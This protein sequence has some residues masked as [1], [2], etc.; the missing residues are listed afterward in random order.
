MER[1]DLIG[2][3]APLCMADGPI[4]SRLARAEELMLG[5]ALADECSVYLWD[6][7]SASFVLGSVVE[8]GKGRV[9]S[10][11]PGEG[12]PGLLGSSAAEVHTEVSGQ[13]RFEGREDR[14]L[15]GFASASVFA[16][17]EPKTL[18]G[19]LYLKFRARASLRAPDRELIAAAVSELALLLGFEELS[20]RNAG[21]GV[22]LD[23]CRGRLKSAEKLAGLA[24]M[25]ATLAH[26]IKSP[27]VSIGGFASRLARKLG[28][29]SEHAGC[30]EQMLTEIRRLEK[31]LNG[32]TSFLM[33]VPLDLRAEDLNAILT[34]AL[35]LFDEEFA[36]HG[37]EVVKGF[38]PGSLSVSA[39]R[40]ELKIAF[41]N[42][43]ANAIQSMDAG[44]VLTL[45][46]EVEEG[47]VVAAFSDTGGGI[48]QANMR[49]IFTPFFTTKEHGTGLG[50]S[51]THSIIAR[52]KGSI[53]VVAKESN[54]A[55]FEVR[56]PAAKAAR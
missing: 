47:F 35:G 40:E 39:D 7:A 6:K 31:V 32:V 46:T 42:L 22:E 23:E 9:E 53:E 33:D 52:H 41:D 27:L 18:Y 37:I 54:G 56:L 25:A 49:D 50:L 45:T 8:G 3:L 17:G 21:L 2:E 24:E 38:Y 11:G 19:L 14:G 29:D 44:G 1:Y 26:E 12:L 16:I 4:G 48:E 36:L 13:G 15:T 34:E 20:R 10:Y 5:A 43:I 51:I 30:V 28:P 55:V